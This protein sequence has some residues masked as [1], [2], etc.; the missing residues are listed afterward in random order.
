MPYGT[1]PASFTAAEMGQYP[2]DSA[3][4]SGDEYV[5][6]GGIYTSDGEDA[7]PSR[8]PSAER[9]SRPPWSSAPRAAAP[10]AQRGPPPPPP[11]IPASGRNYVLDTG[12]VLRP[13]QIEPWTH[14]SFAPLPVYVLQRIGDLNALE[15]PPRLAFDE[16]LTRFVGDL[17]PEL[18]LT[19]AFPPKEYA[20]LTQA[21][22]EG[23]TKSLSPRLYMWTTV[24]HVQLGS[25]KVNRLVLLKETFFHLS[26]VDQARLRQSY[27]MHADQDD[28]G[29]P[30]RSRGRD[31]EELNGEWA[32]PFERLPVQPQIFDVLSYSHRAHNSSSSMLKECRRIGIVSC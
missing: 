15:M 14:S 25:Q 19:A 3:M 9:S 32:R 2:N 17:A 26:A 18:Q 29:A 6:D 1:R 30:G 20:N 4:A 28:L 13:P 12:I 11:P 21:L 31:Y 5:S 24:H 10:A 27:V 22:N 8:P 7:V 16:A 23:N